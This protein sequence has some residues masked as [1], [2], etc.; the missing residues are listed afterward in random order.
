MITVHGRTR[1]GMYHSPI[2]YQ[3]IA[4]VKS[5]VKIPVIG[6]GNISCGADARH[7]MDVTGCDGVAVGRAA[8]GDP[9]VFA[10]ISAYLK[11]KTP[12][13]EPDIITRMNVLREQVDM[14]LEYKSEYV[15][16][17]EARKHTAWYL[18]GVRDAAEFRA[19]AN[20]LNTVADLD[21]YIV[22]VLNSQE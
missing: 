9:F 10:E 16:M 15:T 12:P 5:R 4:E 14:M 21:K 3:T 6:N 1:D 13:D 7:M 11:G 17:Q 20:G 19:M 18:R 2:D 22:T 8:Q